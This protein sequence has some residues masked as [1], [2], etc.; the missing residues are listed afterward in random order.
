VRLGKGQR[1]LSFRHGEFVLF[2]SNGLRVTS[3]IHLEVKISLT[4]TIRLNDVPLKFLLR[5]KGSKSHMVS[6]SRKGTVCCH[7]GNGVD[8]PIGTSL[9]VWEEK[10]Q[11]GIEATPVRSL[12]VA[13]RAVIGRLPG[14]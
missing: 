2:P 6:F 14:A 11:T 9:A 3:Y 12:S 5:K 13:G 7:H 8:G 10:L 4:K 1:P